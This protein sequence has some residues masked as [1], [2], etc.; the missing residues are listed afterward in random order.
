MELAVEEKME[1]ACLYS[2]VFRVQ[3]RTSFDVL[4]DLVQT[5][6]PLLAHN[7]LL[8]CN[9]EGLTVFVDDRHMQVLQEED[10][11]RQGIVLDSM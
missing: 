2:Q 5:W 11:R 10:A 7:F 1:E 4:N 6:E 9:M 3:Q 8:G